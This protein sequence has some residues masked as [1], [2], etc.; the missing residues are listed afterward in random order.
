MPVGM[1]ICLLGVGLTAAAMIDVMDICTNFPMQSTNSKV[2][3]GVK[4]CIQCQGKLS[5]S[6]ILRSDDACIRKL[7]SWIDRP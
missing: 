6:H 2:N 4:L 5:L 3:Q 7:A 1:E